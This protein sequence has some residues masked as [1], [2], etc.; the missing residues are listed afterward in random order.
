[1]LYVL[2]SIYTNS[3]T[4]DEVS[5]PYRKSQDTL[6]GIFYESPRRNQ[7]CTSPVDQVAP[8]LLREGADGYLPKAIRPTRNC[9]RIESHSESQITSKVNTIN[10]K[11]IAPVAP[12]NTHGLIPNKGSL[13]V[14]ATPD[15]EIRDQYDNYVETTFSPSPPIPLPKSAQSDT[16]GCADLPPPPPPSHSP[17]HKSRIQSFIRKKTAKPWPILPLSPS[18]H[19][20]PS[21]I[22]KGSS[23]ASSY[24]TVSDSAALGSSSRFKQMTPSPLSNQA[25][26]KKVGKK[27]LSNRP[28]SAGDGMTRS[29]IRSPSTMGVPSSVGVS[30]NSFI[31]FSANRGTTLLEPRASRMTQGEAA[32]AASQQQ[33][34]VSPSNYS[35]NESVFSGSAPLQGISALESPGINRGSLSTYLDMIPKTAAA[36]PVPMKESNKKADHRRSSSF[37]GFRRPKKENLRQ[38]TMN[39]PSWFKMNRDREKRKQT[40]LESEEK[41]AQ[42][43]RE[44]VDDADSESEMA[45]LMGEDDDD[46]VDNI[47]DVN[48][49][50]GSPNSQKDGIE[51]IDGYMEQ[52]WQ[53]NTGTLSPNQNGQYHRQRCLSDQPYPGLITLSPSVVSSPRSPLSQS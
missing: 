12:L 23:S 51:E 33:S 7:G 30:K 47:N 9:D 46:N 27:L 16:M 22:S 45:Y 52:D 11:R 17:E 39:K 4:Q 50:G 1:M 35:N 36:L 40:E 41:I 31:V 19:D 38:E 3:I 49:H 29:S 15:Q 14:L 26:F 53:S 42:A 10:L 37:D 34:T 6:G 13:P 21:P 48:F 28:R 2:F 44:L 5:P 20:T 8:W 18:F 32:A 24:P 43:E 25:T